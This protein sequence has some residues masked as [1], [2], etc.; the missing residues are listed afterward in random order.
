MVKLFS[1]TWVRNW[2]H[3]SVIVLSLLAN[4]AT[5]VSFCAQP[6]RMVPVANA[7]RVFSEIFKLNEEQQKTV[8]SKLAEIAD[9][10]G[11]VDIET[12]WEV[13]QAIK[14]MPTQA[15][16]AP[17]ILG[18]VEEKEEG[19]QPVKTTKKYK[20]DPET[21][22]AVRRALIAIN[23]RRPGEK[24]DPKSDLIKQLGAHIAGFASPS[25][26]NIPFAPGEISRDLIDV[27]PA[28]KNM[29]VV[30]PIQA[31][32]NGSR[33]AFLSQKDYPIHRVVAWDMQTM[34]EAANFEIK[35]KPNAWTI[36]PNGDKFAFVSSIGDFTKSKITIVDQS[37]KEL[38]AITIERVK[39]SPQDL[40]FSLSGNE[41]SLFDVNASGN[42]LPSEWCA[43]QK[44]WNTNTWAEI[45]SK[46]FERTMVKG[47]RPYFSP[48][49][50]KLIDIS[51]NAVAV[52]NVATKE[53]LQRLTTPPAR[54]ILM[55]TDYYSLPLDW[56]NRR[57]ATY[58]Y[59]ANGATDWFLVTR[60]LNTGAIISQ[61]KIGDDGEGLRVST[62]PIFSPDG[63]YLISQEQGKTTVWNLKELERQYAAS[64]AQ[65]GEQEF[66]GEGE[67]KEMAAAPTPAPVPS[68]PAPAA[69]PPVI[70]RRITV[71]QAMKEFPGD[72]LPTIR[73][74][75]DW[76]KGLEELAAASADRNINYE[77]AWQLF[78][79]IKDR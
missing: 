24:L 7:V 54:K 61:V 20:T 59:N 52:W 51:T 3:K 62:G 72:R 12:G 9:P 40:R 31:C 41:L 36:A 47:L 49:G 39:V 4:M 75:N 33:I 66:K 14:A 15:G 45:G 18:E 64:Q 57:V 77:D 67:S 2:A 13:A 1:S 50:T 21:E 8:A 6:P 38:H 68:S 69:A 34:R 65:A 11:E 73:K 76:V 48:D 70:S 79:T 63:Q 55:L 58:E 22:E 53:V 42:S 78:E 26:W 25:P 44:T 32:A 19:D 29:S 35:D 37:G 16:P 43:T 71:K 60:D 56:E 74:R 28:L 30:P 17:V 10:A 46:K 27:I 23:K 5:H